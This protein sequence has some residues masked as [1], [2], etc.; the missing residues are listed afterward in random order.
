MGSTPESALKEIRR[1]GGPREP[2]LPLLDDVADLPA[3]LRVASLQRQ[4]WWRW[5]LPPAI[6][7]CIVGVAFMPWQQSV[8]G[9]GRVVAY[10]PLE[11]MVTLQSPLAGRV[12]RAHVVEGQVVKRD[13]LLFEIVDNDP[14]LLSNLRLQ[15]DEVVRRREAT[16]NRIAEVTA[17]IEEQQRSL[18]ES[19]AAARQRIAAAEIA[20]ETA[21]L[22][23]DRIKDLYENRF[24]L[25]SQ[26]DYE[27][28]LL[29]QRSTA[30]EL[31]S[32][33]AAYRQREADGSAAIS[34]SRASRESARS[35]LAAAS[36]AVT[37]LDIQI[38]QT[39]MQ[40][41]FAPRDGIVFRVQANEGSFLSPRSALCSIIPETDSR[42]VEVWLDGNDMPLAFGRSTNTV[43]GEVR[44]G[45]EVRVQFE[46]WPAIAIIGPYRSPRGTFG[47]E[48]VLVDPLDN[49]KG[50][51]RVLVAPKPDVIENGAPPR[52]EEWP[53]PRKL[54][55]GVRAQA[56]VLAAQ[57]PLWYEA[58]RLLNGFPANP[59]EEDPDKFE[60]SLTR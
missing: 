38:N 12:Q 47:G 51:F 36:Q 25:A 46:G 18:A 1:D 60:A 23:F 35:D 21:R 24:G 39:S 20:A 11:R 45:S 17:L 6:L 7:L 3:I 13:Q 48:V 42:M 9:T 8:S 56:W 54:R 52:L 4:S 53:P 16:S 43:T 5:L 50:K 55:Q 27:L 32:A 44:P 33:R 22:Q 30:A 58:W 34:V 41:V 2:A 59:A 31:E 10:D 14:N 26:R 29:S 57:V 15:R 49:G 37:Q 28:A 19:L 40:R